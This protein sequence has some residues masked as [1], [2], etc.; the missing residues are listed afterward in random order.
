MVGADGTAQFGV[1]VGAAQLGVGGDLGDEDGGDLVGQP[2]A[3]AF[4]LVDHGVECHRPERRRTLC[5]PITNPGR[6]IPTRHPKTGRSPSHMFISMNLAEN[7]AQ[8]ASR[9]GDRPAL[10]L[11]DKTI[12]YRQLDDRSARVATL[13][14]S[15]GIG[16]GDR[17]GLMMPNVPE[18]A[19]AYYGILRAGAVVVPMNTLL[20]ER[21]VAFYLKDAGAR[22]LVAW[23]GLVEAARGAAARRSRP[24][25]CRTG[26]FRDTAGWHLSQR[27][28]G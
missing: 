28:G 22:L 15:F 11:N 7:L 25:H 27:G 3:A 16:P 26:G 6:T 9:F 2:I 19:M 14:S 23:D 24:G 1:E 21:E 18:F 13:L 5:G 12:T 10:R 8:T 17:V 20:K 4:E